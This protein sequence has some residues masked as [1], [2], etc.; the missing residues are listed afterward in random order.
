MGHGDI[1]HHRGQRCGQDLG[2][3][4]GGDSSPFVNEM[5]RLKRRRDKRPLR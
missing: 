3:L 5:E 4:H 2:E 1:G